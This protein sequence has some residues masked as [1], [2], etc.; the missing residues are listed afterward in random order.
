MDCCSVA[1]DL[2]IERGS[3]EDYKKLSRYHY[4]DETIGPYSDVFVLQCNGRLWLACHT[5]VVGVIVYTMPSCGLELRNTATG[6]VFSG[7]DRKTKMSVVNEY[8][9]CIG[10]VIVEP[11]FRGLGLASRLVRETMPLVDF[12]IIESLA[13]MGFV[14]P[15]FEKAGMKAYRG[16][17][18]RRC[19]Q[20]KEAFS[21]VGIEE[22]ALIDAEAVHNKAAILEREKKVFVDKQMLEF[23]RSYGKRRY[24]RSG[25]ER[26]RFI[27]SKINF[28]P[29]Y[30]YWVNPKFQLAESKTIEGE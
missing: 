20:M 2:R 16:P 25:L 13:V 14:H 19:L 27:L 15:F 3:L 12:P 28:R 6:G 30:Y 24:E 23:L 17:E 4:R 8:V 11:R 21:F 1:R 5:E 22:D 29:V 7:L 26:T 9:R 18:A 10:R